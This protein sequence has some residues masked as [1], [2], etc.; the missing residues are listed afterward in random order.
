MSKR[1][2]DSKPVDSRP[3]VIHRGVIGGGAVSSP[4]EVDDPESVSIENPPPGRAVI[5]VALSVLAFAVIVVVIA[6]WARDGLRTNNNTTGAPA[7]ANLK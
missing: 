1:P 6:T 4:G 3:G 2:V 7:S 5:K